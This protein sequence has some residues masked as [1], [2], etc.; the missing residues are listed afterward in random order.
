MAIFGYDQDLAGQIAELH[1][2]GCGNIFKE[3]ARAPGRIDPS[4]PRRSAGLRLAMCWWSRERA[5]AEGSVQDLSLTPPKSEGA[6]LYAYM[7]SHACRLPVPHS[8]T[9]S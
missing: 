2:A 8:Q 3:K 6:F 1:A 5:Q 9:A 4:W 7:M